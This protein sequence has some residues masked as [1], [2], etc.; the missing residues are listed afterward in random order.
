MLY[1]WTWF[2]LLNV[3]DSAATTDF[4]VVSQLSQDKTIVTQRLSAVATKY[5]ANSQLLS[6]DSTVI[7][8]LL[9]RESIVTQGIQLLSQAL[10]ILTESS[11]CLDSLLSQDL[12][13]V[14][15]Q[16]LSNIQLLSR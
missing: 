13:L 15:N 9:S 1:T 14:R 16:L 3:W 6:R 11:Y 2:D 8:Q 12:A 10:A 7:T 4:G 5:T